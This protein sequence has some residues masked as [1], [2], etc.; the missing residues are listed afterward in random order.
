MDHCCM[1]PF[2]FEEPTSAGCYFD[3]NKG[4]RSEGL[5]GYGSQTRKPCNHLCAQLS[6]VDG[7]RLLKVLARGVLSPV[8]SLL[9][10]VVGGSSGSEGLQARAWP[11]T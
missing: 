7:S 8:V 3:G 2:I 1:L 9:L 6:G 11:G 5:V 10:V 4:S